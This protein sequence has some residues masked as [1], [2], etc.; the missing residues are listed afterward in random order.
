MDPPVL[1]TFIAI[2]SSIAV[3]MCDQYPIWPHLIRI[4]IVMGTRQR[5][6][7]VVD[8]EKRIQGIWTLYHS[9]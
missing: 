1:V 5:M 3:S 4:G 7:P 6:V 2:L 9:I 8:N